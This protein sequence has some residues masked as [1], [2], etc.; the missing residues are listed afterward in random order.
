MNIGVN[1]LREHVSEKVRLHYVIS[2]GGHR[3]NIVPAEAET[4]HYVRAP[5]QDEL[6]EVTNRVRKIAQGAALMTETTYEEFFGGASASVLNNH[7]LAD[8][9][10]EAMKVIGPIEYTA[11]EKAYAEKINA[12]YPKEG[13]QGLLA[14]AGLPIELKDEPLWGDNY[15][16][17]DE[18]K[19]LPGSTD[20][21]DLSW[22]APVSMLYT[23]CSPPGA[24]G[25][26]WGVVASSAHSIG[27]KGMMHAA[28][29]MAVAAMDLYSDPEH[30]RQTRQE[31]KEATG[32]QPYR[33]VQ[34]DDV[35][36]PQYENPYR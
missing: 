4:W 8:L 6:E 11:E 24:T 1:Y 20:L 32:G 10:Y 30:L 3:P 34:P 36:P 33:S 9:H 22:C 26:S 21:G 35:K 17:R 15:A 28:K 13:V 2:H 14:E 12:A 16:A 5:K 7:Y 27:H 25:H 29:I 31:F 23:T 18:G 19:V